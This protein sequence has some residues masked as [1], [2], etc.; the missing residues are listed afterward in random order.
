MDDTCQINELV[1]ETLLKIVAKKLL[2]L[3]IYTE[4]LVFIGLY[5]LEVNLLFL[6]L[7][8]SLQVRH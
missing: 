4:S 6:S 1:Q 5:A 2:T 7:Y 3:F 8:F